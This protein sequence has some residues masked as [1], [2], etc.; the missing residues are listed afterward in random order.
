MDWYEKLLGD[1]KREWGEVGVKDDSQVLGL[2]HRVDDNAFIEMERKIQVILLKRKGFCEPQY[3]ELDG[4]TK[5]C[6]QNY[7]I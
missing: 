1:K 6:P 5:K 7:Y 3:K 4:S 2:G